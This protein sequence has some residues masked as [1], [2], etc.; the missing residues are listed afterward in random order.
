MNFV[1]I[2]KWLIGPI[3]R[4]V[5]IGAAL[6]GL[7]YYGYDSLRDSWVEQGRAEVQVEFDKYKIAQTKMLHEAKATALKIEAEERA[8][9]EAARVK[10]QQEKDDAQLTY[11]RDLGRL[12]DGTLKLRKHWG[13]CE[14]DRLATEAELAAR[15]DENAR[16]RQE[17]AARIV[18]LADDA[19]AWIKAFQGSCG[20]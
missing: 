13:V 3:G 19:D 4:Y 1:T 17:S 7:L 20:Q 9:F 15:A 12:R 8:R 14:T 5:L 11:E 2:G 10:W 6:V 18:R 16:L